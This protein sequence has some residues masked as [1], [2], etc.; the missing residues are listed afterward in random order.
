MKKA[1]LIII[2]LASSAIAFAQPLNKIDPSAITIGGEIGRRIDITVDNNL[3]AVDIDKDFLAPFQERKQMDG[4]IGVGMFL[5]AAV[6]LAHHT[7]NE[8]LIALKNHI[9]DTL[10]ATQEPDGYIGLMR[11]LA[12]IR[13]LWDV[14]ELSY[15][16]IGLTNDGLLFQRTDSLDAARKLADYLVT[17]LTETPPPGCYDGDLNPV[18]SNT[19]LADALLLLT[20]AT[21][22]DKYKQFILDVLDMAHWAKPIVCGRHW[23]IDGHIY[24][25]LDKCLVQLHLDPTASNP[26]LRAM[27]DGVLKFMLEDNGLT[28]SG[29]CGDHEC[30]QNTQAGMN[31]LAETCATVY[32]LRFYDELLRQTGDPVYGDLMERTIYNT[33]FGAQSPDGRKLRYYTGF[34]APRVYFDGDTYCCPDNYRRGIAD[35]PEYIVYTTKDGVLVNL[36]TECDAQTNLPDGGSLQLTMKTEYPSKEDITLLI[37]PEKETAFT[38]SLRI[39]KWCAKPEVKVNG[40]P[41]EAEILTGALCDLKRTWKQGDEVQVKLPMKWRFVKGRRSQIGRVAIMRGPQVFGLNPNRKENNLDGIAPRLY[42][43]NPESLEGPT[44]DDSVRPGG[45]ACTVGVWRPEVFYP[46]KI[47]KTLTLTEFADPGCEHIYFHVPNPN[48][49]LFVNDEL[50]PNAHE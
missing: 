22:N 23:P 16:I 35:L 24:G 20:D 12:R 38:L 49:P 10:M 27:S 45:L 33:L 47:S 11:P 17:R 41:I 25:Y 15:I 31:N 26:E 32:Q 5:D 18:M 19:G 9:A 3:L 50:F 46:G 39:P 40:T 14:H 42:A 4:F 30:F 13:K 29:G 48:D 44:P 8:K 6:R 37:A 21:G 2:L 28:I 34:E 43:M 36:Y 7:Q 1:T